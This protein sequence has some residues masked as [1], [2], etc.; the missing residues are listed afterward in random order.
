MRGS[1]G[2]APSCQKQGG[3]GAYPLALGDFYIFFNKNNAFLGYLGLNF[4][5]LM[6]KQK[7]RALA[8]LPTTTIRQ[9]YKNRI[10]DT[11]SALTA[12]Q[13]QSSPP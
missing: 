1:G 9:K 12:Q 3:L 10:P 6:M 4:S 8:P 11:T 5:I 7:S 2:G 13:R